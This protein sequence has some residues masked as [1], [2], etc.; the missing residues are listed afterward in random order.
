MKISTIVRTLSGVVVLSLALLVAV[1]FADDKPVSDEELGIRKTTLMTEELVVPASSDKLPNAGDSETIDRSFENCPPNIPHAIAD[2]VPITLDDNQCI[3]CHLPDVA[4][5][6]GATSVPASHMY[7]IRTQQETGSQLN[8]AMYSCML[9]H[10]AMTDAD[11]V[12]DNN[13]QA[14]FRDQGDATSSNLLDI[15]NEGVE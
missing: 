15:L 10:A 8:G 14:E 13:F 11:P 7:D 4:E 12:I 9:C 1:A 2:F 6:F 3:E 5:D